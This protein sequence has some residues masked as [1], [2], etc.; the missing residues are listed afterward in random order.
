MIPLFKVA[1]N[2]ETALANV[3]GVLESGYVGQG[4]WCERFEEAVKTVTGHERLLYL[5][6]GTSALQLAVYLSGAGPGCEV[7]STP[8]TCLATNAAIVANGA[9]IVWAD[10]EPDT[11]NMDMADAASKVTSRTRAIIGVDWGGRVCK[12]DQFRRAIRGVSLIEDAA[13][14]LLATG[15]GRGDFACYSFQ[16]IKHLNTADGGALVCPSTAI[17]ERAKLLRWFGLDR[18]RSD[19]MRCYQPVNESGWKF[20]GNDVLAAIG[21][22]NVPGLQERVMAHR[23]NAD[24]FATRLAG[25]AYI[26]RPPPDFLSAWWLYTIKVSNPAVFEGFMAA[27]GVAV[28]QVHARNDLYS[29]YN[30]YKVDNLPG[31]DSFSAHQTNIPVGW[32]L[33]EDDRE[34]IA[35]AIEDWAKTPAAVWSMT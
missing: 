9:K 22:A 33:T 25:T 10:V 8:I 1:T 13:H 26:R 18:T 27:K 29:C 31:V 35:R 15:E 6:S 21:C 3:R 20:Q 5:N 7:I 12:F 32:W 17:H 19:A 23:A 2:V 4:K 28:S 34:C 14:A 16:A 11:G 24:W 30:P